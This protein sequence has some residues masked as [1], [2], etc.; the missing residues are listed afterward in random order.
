MR[1]SGSFL[2][3]IFFGVIVSL[4]TTFIVHRYDGAQTAAPESVYDRVMRT[5]T[6]RCGY[7][8]YDPLV[9]KD[10]SGALHG[11]FF[12]LANEM[13]REL[14]LKI[15]WTAE[16]GY[17]EIEEGFLANKYDVFC[18]GAAITPKRGKFSY[19][20]TPIYYQT[21]VV[22]VRADDHRFDANLSRL[23][24]PDVTLAV[25]DGDLPETIARLSFP[26]A[27]TISSPQ[28]ADYTQMFMDV[29]T[30][31][32]DA[33]FF[34]KSFGDKYLAQNPGGLKIARP[35][36]PVYTIP[37]AMMLPMGADKLK[38]VLDTALAK[39]ILNGQ[40]EEAFKRNAPSYDLWGTAQPY[41]HVT[42]STP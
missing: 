31:K 11:V 21:D 2:F 24:A 27:K 15:E 4:V 19:Y 13:G 7:A 33:V 23:N 25:R 8:L 35:D 38:S 17:G 40:I 37:V 22:W 28:S 12:D 29:Q 32:A 14:G 1:K 34:E 39:M 30:G 20:T 9:I 26:K 5:G 10:P 3:L 36:T 6:L 41:R 18:T 42:G 16:V